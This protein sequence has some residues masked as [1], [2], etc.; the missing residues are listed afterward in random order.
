MW[1]RTQNFGTYLIS[2]LTLFKANK[3]SIRF[4]TVKSGW[5]IVYIEGLLVET[6]QMYRLV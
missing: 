3:L 2:L 6:K 4:D 5:S 1:V